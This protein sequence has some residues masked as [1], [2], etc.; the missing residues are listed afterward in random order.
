MCFELDSTM[1]KLE[2]LEMFVY[3]EWENNTKNWRYPEVNNA[4][5]RNGIF[6]KQDYI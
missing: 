6:E 2:K 5:K 1:G 3:N 4:Y